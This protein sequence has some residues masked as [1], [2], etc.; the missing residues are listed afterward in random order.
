MGGMTRRS[1]RIGWRRGL[2]WAAALVGGVLPV[3][4]EVR[5]HDAFIDASK[6]TL[7]SLLDPS[8]WLGAQ[9]GG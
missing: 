3:T 7:V 5:L 2:L 8:K 9:G 6:Q 1:G 4:C